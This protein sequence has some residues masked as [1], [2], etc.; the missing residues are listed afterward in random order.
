MPPPSCWIGLLLLTACAGSGDGSTGDAGVA[1]PRPAPSHLEA[2]G[3]LR[4]IHLRWTASD[5]AAGYHVYRSA[6][7]AE[8]VRRTGAAILAT[9]YDDPIESPGGDGVLYSYQ[10]T[11]VEVLD[12]DRPAVGGARESGFSNLAATMHGTRLKGPYPPY[13]APASSPYVIEGNTV[14]ESGLSVA[15]GSQLY[16]LPGAV[17]DFPA[18]SGGTGSGAALDV[19]GVLRA[20]GTPSAPV[21]FT[22]HTPDGEP[23]VDG[24]GFWFMFSGDG[25]DARDGSG[26]VLDHVRMDHLASNPIHEGGIIV[27]YG[28]AV[29]SEL[30]LR[31][32]KLSGASSDGSVCLLLRRAASLEDSFLDRVSLCIDTSLPRAQLQITRNVFR[33]SPIIVDR[34]ATTPAGP[35]Q[36][37]GNDL[38]GVAGVAS[39][40]GSLPLGGNYWAG[41]PGVPPTPRSV[42]SGSPADF[43][44]PGPPLAEPPSAG[45]DW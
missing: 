7:G 40:G 24:E 20:I 13:T 10:V 31:H 3:S 21:R 38:D 4:S 23:L 44:N 32:V 43:S 30:K 27:E 15:R 2:T 8:F 17:L 39:E 22:A 34:H 18:G 36:I 37:A 25:Y 42:G 5:G 11:A 9:S 29:N 45:P 12:G 26:S 1:A 14:F 35:G 16:V 28:D 33:H 19:R 6:D 41:A